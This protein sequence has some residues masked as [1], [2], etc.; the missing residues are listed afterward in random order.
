[1]SPQVAPSLTQN[2]RT[3]ASLY[4]QLPV[5]GQLG[6]LEYLVD[7]ENLEMYRSAVGYPEAGFP[8]LALAEYRQVLTNKYG[9]MSLTSVRHQEWYFRPP[10]LGRRIQVSGWIR[11]KY[12]RLGQDWLVVG[13]LA[14]DEIGTEVL[15]SQH[16]FIL[17]KEE[18]PEVFQTGSLPTGNT[19]KALAHL[20]KRLSPEVLE[21]FRALYQKLALACAWDVDQPNSAKLMSFAYLHELMASNYGIDFR[22]GGELDVRFLK[23]LRSG[24]KYTAHGSI[25]QEKREGNRTSLHLRVWLETQDGSTAASGQAKVTVPSP[26]T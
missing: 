16:T 9:S 8:S 6:H 26:L 20:E 17:G 19:V 2:D 4:Q 10:I 22:Q 1:M 24:E 12:H 7:Q 25:T 21:V 3:G 5:G 18:P 11:D 13:T 23:P 14:V 15:R